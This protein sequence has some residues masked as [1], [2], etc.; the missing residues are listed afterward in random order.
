MAFLVSREELDLGGDRLGREQ[1]RGS[2]S[3]W[4][5]TGVVRLELQ[6]GG[7]MGHGSGGQGA[8]GRTARERCDLERRAR[9]G[10]RRESSGRWFL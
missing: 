7:S 5:G 9:V 6:R 2:A 10:D 3:R 8:A 4:P 1:G